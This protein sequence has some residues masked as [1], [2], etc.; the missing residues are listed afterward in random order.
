MVLKSNE[1]NIHLTQCRVD[2]TKF[3]FVTRERKNTFGH[4][5]AQSGDSLSYWWLLVSTCESIA[6]CS[7]RAL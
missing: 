6:K 2:I 5:H 1:N 3:T 7:A 4:A